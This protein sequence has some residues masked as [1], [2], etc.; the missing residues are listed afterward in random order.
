MQ[1]ISW[2]CAWCRA[3]KLPSTYL[4]AALL[5][6]WFARRGANKHV[7]RDYLI[8]FF[9]AVIP[10]E[11]AHTFLGLNAAIL[12]SLRNNQA[13]VCR[14]W[15]GAIA[16]TV[17]LWAMHIF[18]IHYRENVAA[19][20][21]IR[22][23]LKKS[24]CF[25]SDK[26]ET[27]GSLNLKQWVAIM[28]PIPQRMALRLAYPGVT[29]IKTVAYAHVGL[30]NLTP[31][32]MDVYKARSAPPNVPVVVYVHGGG[33]VGGTR[34]YP[35]LPLVYQMA[36]R[37]WLI[38]V[39]DY[40]LSPKVAFPEH[41]IDIKRSIAYL[42]KNARREFDANPDFIVVAGESAGAHLAS[43]VALTSGMKELQPGFETVDTSVKGCIDAYGVHDITDRFGVHIHKDKGR[44]FV[45]FME[46]IV[47]QCRMDQHQEAYA[48]ASPISWVMADEIPQLK[49]NQVIPPFLVAHGTMDTLIPFDDSSFFFEQLQRYRER[50][51]QWNGGI[52]DVFIELSG[53]HHAFNYFMSPR[54]LAFGDA[55]CL[56]L[57]AL[58]TKAVT[59]RATLSQLRC[60]L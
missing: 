12:W 36:S 41:L 34:V 10:T 21:L 4:A 33:W 28:L 27:V 37:G 32:L 3:R 15:M 19:K 52:H 18:L 1:L 9:L 42:R 45:R 55:V 31:L 16:V 11:L 7:P 14:H 30:H 38:C 53:V 58:H 24:G 57:D 35:P 13:R 5:M 51:N 48:V 47:M 26:V 46:L 20:H 17:Q 22:S 59:P 50:T 39:V 29:K 23:V 8:T 60:S 44:D 43:L 25:G 6:L 40:R 49:T 56:F 54:A 2:I